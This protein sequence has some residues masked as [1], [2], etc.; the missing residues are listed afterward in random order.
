MGKRQRRSLGGA[1]K[2]SLFAG[3]ERED[4]IDSMGGVC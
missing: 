4:R 2:P 3:E 1:G